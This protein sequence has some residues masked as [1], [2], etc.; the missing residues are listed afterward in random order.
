VDV[1]ECTVGSQAEP[2]SC[3]FETPL[4]GRY[5]IT[6]TVTDSLG[7]QNMSQFERW[8]SGGELPPSRKVEQETL[9]LIPDKE[10]YQ[11]GDSAQILVQSPFSPLKD[12]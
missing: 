9:T 2:V 12:C 10:S 1:Q 3:T 11:P 6:A 5:Q 7:R 8:V 4:G